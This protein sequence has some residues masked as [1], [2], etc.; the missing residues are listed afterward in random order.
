MSLDTNN[1]K[2]SFSEVANTVARKIMNLYSKAS[3]PS[4]TKERIVQLINKYHDKYYKI[5][6]SYHRDINKSDFKKQI[7][8]TA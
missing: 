8:E 5:R 2:V 3:I 6:K 1:K 7:S 4:V